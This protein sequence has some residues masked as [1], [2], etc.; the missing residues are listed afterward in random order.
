VLAWGGIPDGNPRTGP[1][2]SA[3]GFRN[4][5]GTAFDRRIADLDALLHPSGQMLSLESSELL[6][7]GGM[8]VAWMS[9]IGSDKTW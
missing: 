1:A 8:M 3:Y 5:F 2:C 9:R 7:A 4:S 6:R